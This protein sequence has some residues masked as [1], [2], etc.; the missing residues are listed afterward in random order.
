MAD[1]LSPEGKLDISTVP[2]LHQSLIA[3]AGQDIVIDLAA[4]TQVGGLCLQTFL[5]AAKDAKKSGNTF[6]LI[7]ASDVVATQ[8]GSMGYSPET[9]TENA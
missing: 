5:A 8:L 1:P 3:Q 7:N 6:A 2:N 4:V 9:L